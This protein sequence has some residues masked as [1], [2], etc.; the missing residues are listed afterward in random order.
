M[1]V[2]LI[3]GSYPPMR[4]GVGDYTDRLAYALRSYSKIKVDVLTSTLDTQGLS[5]AQREIHYVMPTWGKAGLRCFVTMMRRIRPDVVHIQ[6]PTQGYVLAVG[7]LAWIPLISRFLFGVPVVQTWHE[8]VPTRE[9]NILRCM[10]GMALGASALIVVRPDYAS[11]IPKF[12]RLLLRTTPISFIQNVSSIPTKILTS[13]E[14][15]AIRGQLGSGSSQ[16]I[17]HFGFAFAHKGTD[18][19]FQLAN[20][21]KH[22]LLLIGDLSLDDPYHARLRRLA[23]TPEWNGKV[24]ITGFVEAREAARLVAAADAVV[25]PHLAGGGIWNTAMHAAMSQ[26]T[27]VVATSTEKSGYDAAA[28]VYYAK[29]GDINEMRSALSSY[30]GIRNPNATSAEESWQTLA[31]AHEALY[32]SL[33]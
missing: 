13:E 1:R 31:R 6:F 22:H 32:R 17:A 18:L 12:M 19:L 2:L 23:A 25:F 16:I 11:K 9:P 30:A 33:K 14:R 27:F 10:Y 20:P 3:S 26:G 8:Y 28:N 5:H 7:A 24:T 29:P 4:C 15:A 21:E